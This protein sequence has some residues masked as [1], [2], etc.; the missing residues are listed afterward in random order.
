MLARLRRFVLYVRLVR[1]ALICPL[2]DG[3]IALAYYLFDGR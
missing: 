1:F 2:D 3:T